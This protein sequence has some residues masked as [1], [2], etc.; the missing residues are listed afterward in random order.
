ML[1]TRATLLAAVIGVLALTLA[2]PLRLYLQQREDIVELSAQNAEQQRRLDELR[3]TAARYDDPAWVDDEVRRRLHYLR[4]GEQA[5]LMP[6]EEE[7]SAPP[8]AAVGAAAGAATGRS[9]WYGRLWSDL[10]KTAMPAPATPSPTPT[11]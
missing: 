9:A 6:A 1:T 11:R 10:F 7:P 8:P 2:F 4:P 5:Y 3:R